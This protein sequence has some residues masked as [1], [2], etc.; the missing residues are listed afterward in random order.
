MSS[1]AII[2]VVLGV[3]ADSILA[4]VGNRKKFRLKNKKYVIHH[5]VYGLIFLVIGLILS[6]FLL[7]FGMGIII[8]H[9]VRLKKLVFIEKIKRRKNAKS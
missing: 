5:S 9:T 2:G 3:L 6:E 7:W 1:L 4:F 8:G